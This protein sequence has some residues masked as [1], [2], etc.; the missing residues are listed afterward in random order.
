MR[1]LVLFRDRWPEFFQGE[2]GYMSMSRLLAFLSLFPASWALVVNPVEG[3][4]LAYTGVYGAMYVGGKV[5]DKMRS[6]KEEK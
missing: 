2:G 6:D 1:C 4:L 5:A 3:M